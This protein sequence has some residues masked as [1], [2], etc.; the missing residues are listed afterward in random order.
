MTAMVRCTIQIQATKVLPSLWLNQS[1]SKS[2]CIVVDGAVVLICLICP[3]AFGGD[4]P[5]HH[6]LHQPGSGSAN[7]GFS[8]HA[9]PYPACV[10]V[11]SVFFFTRLF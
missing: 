1:T 9:Q 11:A 10:H 6:A 3:G 4:V 8:I 5:A 7:L 2:K